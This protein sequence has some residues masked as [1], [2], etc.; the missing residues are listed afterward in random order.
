LSK[1]RGYLG[2]QRVLGRAWLNEDIFTI[3]AEFC[4]HVRARRRRKRCGEPSIEASISSKALM[5]GS[6]CINNTR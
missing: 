6:E 4:R 1:G 2:I 5:R 3:P